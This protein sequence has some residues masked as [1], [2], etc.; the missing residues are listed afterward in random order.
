MAFLKRYFTLLKCYFIFLKYTLVSLIPA[1]LRKRSLL[2][3]LSL[4][5]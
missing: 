2:K 3:V 1:S 4:I 5:Q